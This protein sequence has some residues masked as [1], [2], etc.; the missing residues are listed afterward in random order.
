M[1]YPELCVSNIKENTMPRLIAHFKRWIIYERWVTELSLNHACVDETSN[2]S[3]SVISRLKPT[4]NGVRH[5]FTF[6]FREQVNRGFL[7]PITVGYGPS[8]ALVPVIKSQNTVNVVSISIVLHYFSKECVLNT[9]IN[10]TNFS[11]SQINEWSKERLMHKHLCLFKVTFVQINQ[12]SK[13]RETKRN[14]QT[15]THKTHTRKKKHF[16]LDS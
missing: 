11:K 4:R 16:V 8:D 13:W 6:W 10:V 5:Q 1:T 12:T 9:T 7:C 2:L 14:P 15:M 3:I